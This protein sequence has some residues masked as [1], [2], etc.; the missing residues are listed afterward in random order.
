M[1]LALFLTPPLGFSNKQLSLL[2][3]E[4]TLPSFATIS[5]TSLKNNHFHF[6]FLRNFRLL[7]PLFVLWQPSIYILLIQ[8]GSTAAKSLRANLKYAPYSRSRTLQRNQNFE[9]KGLKIN[10]EFEGEKETHCFQISK[11]N[12]PVPVLTDE[13]LT[14]TRLGKRTNKKF[15]SNAER[16]LPLSC[17]M[18]KW[19]WK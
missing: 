14:G 3:Y 12:F 9:R 6:L 5:L 17:V 13:T 1:T 7:S 10:I 2:L 18:H 15:N 8:G 4:K 11:N 19:K 16:Q